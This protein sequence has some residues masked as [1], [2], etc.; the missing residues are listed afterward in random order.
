MCEAITRTE[1][2]SS[3]T[4][5]QAAYATASINLAKRENAGWMNDTPERPGHFQE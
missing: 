4:S 2:T 5:S 3:K 1:S